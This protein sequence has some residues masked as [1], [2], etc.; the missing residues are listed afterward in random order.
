MTP[1]YQAMIR[2]T[3][4]LTYFALGICAVSLVVAYVPLDIIFYA[5]LILLG[6]MLARLVYTVVL[7]RIEQD[8]PNKK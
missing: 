5:F 7:E 6:G 1:K 8:L 4:I 3:Q 2:T